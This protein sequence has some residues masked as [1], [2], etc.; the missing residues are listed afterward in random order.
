MPAYTGSWLVYRAPWQ[1]GN[2]SVTEEESIDVMGLPGV[3][4]EEPMME[5]TSG[6]FSSRALR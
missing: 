1:F 2:D 3:M 4:D 6:E 5:L